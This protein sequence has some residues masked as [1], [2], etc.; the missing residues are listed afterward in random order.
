MVVVWWVW[1]GDTGALSAACWAAMV[2]IGEEGYLKV[3]GNLAI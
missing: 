2:H 3:R 1:G